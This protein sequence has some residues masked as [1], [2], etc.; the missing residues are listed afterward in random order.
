MNRNLPW[1]FV[2]VMLIAVAP[3]FAGGKATQMWRCELDDDATEEQ[4]VEAAH[5]WLAAAKTMK[6]GKNLEASIYFPVAVNNLPH[7]DLLFVVSAPTFEEWGTFWDGYKDSPAA[8]LDKAHRDFIVAPNSALWESI[9]VKLPAGSAAPTSDMK[10]T[11]MWRCELDDDAT[12]EQVVEAAQKW[13][14]AARKMDGCANLQAS[15]HFPVAVNANGEHDLIFVVQ[16][17]T[18]KEWGTF[19]DG[20]KGSEVAKLDKAN[21]D[22]IIAPN[23]ALWESIKVGTTK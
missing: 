15:V 8:K 21:R 14:A 5:E 13:L 22:F 2:A 9:K 12:E 10:A 11:Q 4:V 19:W 1:M 20:Y 7:T 16:A 18:F 17:P 3:A 23:S 6:G